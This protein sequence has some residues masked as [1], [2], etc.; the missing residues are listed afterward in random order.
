MK[1][2]APARPAEMQRLP[3]ARTPGLGPLPRPRRLACFL[4][5]LDGG[6]AE[7]VV[8]NVA[9]ALARRGYSVDLVLGR[10]KGAYVGQVSNELDVVLLNCR[11]TILGVL[12]LAR[13]LGRRRPEVLMST[14]I[15]GNI[16]A[17]AATRCVPDRSVR[18]V[19]RLDHTF[20]TTC[21]IDPHVGGRLRFLLLEHAL[22]RADAVV[23]VSSGVTADLVRHV[24]GAGPRVRTVPN[25]AFRQQIVADVA[26]PATHRWLCDDAPPVVLAAGRLEPGKDYPTLLA[27]FARVV[28]DRQARLLII[29]EGRERDRL[30]ALARKLRI[31]EFVDMPGFQSNPYAYMARAQVFVLSSCT[32]GMPNVLVEA[33]ACGT[34]VVSTDCP[35]GP[36][37]VLEDGKWGKLVPVGDPEAL[38]AAILRTLDEVPDRES[39]VARA[40]S[41]S[42]GP[43]VDAY[44]RI[45]FPCAPDL[46]K[47]NSLQPPPDDSESRSRR[48]PRSRQNDATSSAPA[49]SNG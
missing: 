2:G 33:M 35:H 45:L 38:S 11:K 19:L 41:F 37:E 6:G 7:R 30:T 42:L 13:Y 43:A 25:P 46:A 39:L 32:E 24:P 36:R 28:E 23:T 48:K 14:T 29:G 27:A 3:D 34:P 17:F 44:E 22:H 9:T 12:P 1:T 21:A 10:R 5:S 49:V 15:T 31:D 16:V 18:T 40:R 4:P 20:S 26:A 8:L 47:V